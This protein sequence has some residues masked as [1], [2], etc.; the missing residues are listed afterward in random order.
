MSLGKDLST[1]TSTFFEAFSFIFKH[2]LWYYYLF[3]L[4]IY[5]LLIFGVFELSSWASESLVDGIAGWMGFSTEEA[6]DPEDLAWYEYIWNFFKTGFSFVSK[7]AFNVVIAGVGAILVKYIT[8]IL[9][10]PILAF[11]SEKVEKIITGNDY[12]TDWDQIMRDIWRGVLIALR[13]MCIEYGIAIPAFL[14]TIAFPPLTLIITPFQWIIGWYF[15]GFSMMDYVNERRRLS[16]K[17][18]VKFVR[19]QKGIAISNGF[20]FAMLDK[21]PVLGIMIAP[22]NACVGATLAIH[23]QIDLGTNPYAQRAPEEPKA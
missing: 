16:V 10:S 23:K 2:N 22:I 20:W 9:L 17:E 1:G 5:V 8:L 11:L 7:I 4:I 6:G 21:V 12:P 14:L 3:P 15:L 18:S 19:K 13:N